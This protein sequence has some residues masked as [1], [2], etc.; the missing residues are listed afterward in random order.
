MNTTAAKAAAETCLLDE[1]A[2][3]ESG[4]LEPDG[5]AGVLIVE[6]EEPLLAIPEAEPVATAVEKPERTGVKDT[7]TEAE[8]EPEA[9]AV[10]VMELELI[11]EV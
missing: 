8:E 2:P 11:A 4:T 7:V 1:A 9:E 10:G 3:V 6:L 5:G